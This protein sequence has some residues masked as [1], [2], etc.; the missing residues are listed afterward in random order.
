GARGGQEPG[1]GGGRG[2]KDGTAG[3]GSAASRSAGTSSSRWTG[4]AGTGS[5]SRSRGRS[6]APWLP[7]HKL[8]RSVFGTRNVAMERITDWNPLQEPD[9]GEGDH[10]DG[11]R[12]GQGR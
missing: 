6:S 8:R 11:A 5:G 10:H 1:A 3:P 7:A 4:S 12:A 9:D 2:G